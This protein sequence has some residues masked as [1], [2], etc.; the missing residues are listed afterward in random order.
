MSQDILNAIRHAS[1]A[2]ALEIINALLCTF[3][4]CTPVGDSLLDAALV[5]DDKLNN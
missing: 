5:L 3:K 4:P 1:E 2:E